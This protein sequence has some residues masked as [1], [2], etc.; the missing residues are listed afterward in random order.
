L[1]S[2][3]VVDVT[4]SAKASWKTDGFIFTFPLLLKGCETIR[5]ASS[6]PS[7]E[8]S[9][10]P[11]GCGGKITELCRVDLVNAACGKETPLTKS[12]T[13]I[14]TYTNIIYKGTL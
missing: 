14:Y 13:H 12:L 11:F 7:R 6:R 2:E 1:P 5:L 9:S 3:L 10:P 8:I 4:K